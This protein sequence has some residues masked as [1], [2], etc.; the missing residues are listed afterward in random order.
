MNDES[1][2][3]YYKNITRDM[4]GRVLR[5]HGI[6]RKEGNTYSLEDFDGLSQDQINDL[7]AL[8]QAKL[9]EY[10]QKRGERIWQHRKQSNGT[11][12]EPCGTR[13]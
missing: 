6:V 2:I 10:T 7:V 13:S 5:N 9:D 1:Q 3:D 12:L 4:V 8:C 11:A